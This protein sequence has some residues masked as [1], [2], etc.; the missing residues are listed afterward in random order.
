MHCF[1]GSLGC[2]RLIYSQFSA[3]NVPEASDYC[4]CK[5]TIFKDERPSS[6]T[7]FVFADIITVLFVGLVGYFNVHK[8]LLVLHKLYDEVCVWFLS[9]VSVISSKLHC[10]S[11]NYLLPRR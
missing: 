10:I 3:S 2:I 1:R 6:R 4:T 8:M 11:Q 9:F 5:R 7:Q